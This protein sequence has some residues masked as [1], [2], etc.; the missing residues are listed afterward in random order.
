MIN[1]NK[2]PA[3]LKRTKKEPKSLPHPIIVD[4]TKINVIQADQETI[5]GSKRI[6]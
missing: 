1:V 6:E 2:K 3:N 4:N 5:M